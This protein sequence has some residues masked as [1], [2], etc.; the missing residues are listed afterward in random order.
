MHYIRNYLEENAMKHISAIITALVITAVV[1]L[2]IA[3][4]GANALTN[5]NT[6]PLQNSPNSSVAGSS[7]PGNDPAGQ[8]ATTT[9]N[10]QQLQQEVNSLQ[11]QLN[12]ENQAL[13][14]YQSLIQALQQNGVIYIDRNGNIY[15][16]Q[17]GSGVNR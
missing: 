16:P 3:V 1:G 15:I 5:T 11:S 2:G 9:T 14:Q 13:Q 6:V 4:I 17:G 12:Q 10:V 8:A 7:Q